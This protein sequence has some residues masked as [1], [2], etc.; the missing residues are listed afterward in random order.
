MNRQRDARLTILSFAQCAKDSTV[1]CH[2]CD[3]IVSEYYAIQLERCTSVFCDRCT[4]L[5]IHREAAVGA[6]SEA[7]VG[8]T[9]KAGRDVYARLHKR[10]KQKE[11]LQQKRPLALHVQHQQQDA[12]RT[13]TVPGVQR[14]LALAQQQ[15]NQVL[16]PDCQLREWIEKQ[17]QPVQTLLFELHE[18][19]LQQDQQQHRQQEK[20]KRSIG[21]DRRRT[22]PQSWQLAAAKNVLSKAS[23]AKARA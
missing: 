11:A 6:T 16:V 22:L 17:E 7:A 23:L 18:Q 2:T 10:R 4:A 13:L 15:T 19:A 20:S 12:A 21:P 8:A 14:P 5:L 1:R 9:A 3:R